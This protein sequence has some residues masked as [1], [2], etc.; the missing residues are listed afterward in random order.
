[1]FFI[2]CTHECPEEYADLIRMIACNSPV[3][4]AF[5]LQY[6]NMVEDVLRDSKFIQNGNLMKQLQLKMPVLFDLLCRLRHVPSFLKVI[7]ERICN[8]T[9]KSFTGSSGHV[10]SGS[11]KED[12]L[13]FFPNLP[14]LCQRGEYVMD[15]T[16]GEKVCTKHT[17]SHPSLLPGTFTVFCPHGKNIY[18]VFF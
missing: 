10:T 3:C 7:L 17:G 2:G 16:R 14:K 12:S 1:M 9:R 6:L 18:W 5:P 8:I 11:V 15:K 4:A 13:A